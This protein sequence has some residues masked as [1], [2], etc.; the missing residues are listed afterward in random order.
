MGTIRTR[1]W[2]LG[3]AAFLTLSGCSNPVADNGHRTMRDVVITSADGATLVQT[4]DN[5]SWVGAPLVLTPGEA[6]AVSIFFIAPD[7]T[8]FQ[9]PASGAS[10]TLHVATEQ[11]EIARYEPLSATTGQFVSQASGATTA[12]IYLW[13]GVHPSGHADAASPPLPIVVE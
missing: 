4:Q 7:G 10:H 13:H 12:I 6:L 2:T 1:A 5:Q 9:L 8:Q 3:L 11:P